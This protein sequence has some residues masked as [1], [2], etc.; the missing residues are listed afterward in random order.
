MAPLR[1]GSGPHREPWNRMSIQVT[2][3]Q[4]CPRSLPAREP[5]SHTRESRGRAPQANEYTHMYTHTIDFVQ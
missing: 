3:S 4:D 5:G 2:R 1:K